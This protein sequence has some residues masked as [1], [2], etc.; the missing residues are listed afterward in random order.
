MIP[1]SFEYHAPNSVQEV[2]ALLTE[3]EDAKIIAG[4]HSLLP[5]MKFRLAEPPHLIDIK[6]IHELKGISLE[7]NTL[8]IGSM[9]NENELIA[10]ELLQQHC[11]LLPFAAKLIADPQIRNKGT[12][13]GDIA[14]GD[15]GNDHPALM[16]ALDAEFVIEGPEG[17]RTVPANGFYM[18]TYWTQLEETDL[19]KTIRIPA[20]SKTTFFGYNKLKRKTGDFATAGAT[21]LLD[22]NQG[23]ITKARIA[24]TNVAPTAIRAENAE[25]ILQGCHVDAIPMQ[26]VLEAIMSEVDPGED[27]RGST[28]YKTHM[29]A[30]MAK[31]SIND[32]IA[33]SKG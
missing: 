19:L 10:S 9:T 20:P 14:H 25:A 12:I 4:G 29:A 5:M 23:Q 30:E 22:I 17:Q 24:L 8:V 27:L 6:N 15:P 32:A 18:G 1:G 2:I 31:R 7:G 16:M 33:S 21:A 3:Y 28:E 11:P 13:G 26:Q